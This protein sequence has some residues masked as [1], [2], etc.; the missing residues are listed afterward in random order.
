MSN[1]FLQQIYKLIIRFLPVQIFVRFPISPVLLGGAC[2]IGRRTIEPGLIRD[3]AFTGGP[4]RMAISP[5]LPGHFNISFN[6]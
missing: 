2:G 6:L 4:I 3:G 5:Y 1:E